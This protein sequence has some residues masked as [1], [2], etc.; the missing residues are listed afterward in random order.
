MSGW[1]REKISSGKH[2]NPVSFYTAEEDMEVDIP[3]DYQSEDIPGLQFEDDPEMDLY[4]DYDSDDE[5][6]SQEQE[7]LSQEET[8]E[9]EGILLRYIH[10]NRKLNH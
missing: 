3:A 1:I 4:L 10:G 7:P 9:L 5:H 6:V 8:Q 2:T